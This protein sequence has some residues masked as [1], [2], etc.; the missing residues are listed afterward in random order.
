MSSVNDDHPGRGSL[1]PLSCSRTAAP[2][3]CQDKD[4]EVGSCPNPWKERPYGVESRSYDAYL[5]TGSYAQWPF[6]YLH[7][8]VGFCQLSAL[9]HGCSHL[10][11]QAHPSPCLHLPSATCPSY[12]T[13]N[14]IPPASICQGHQASQSEGHWTDR[15]PFRAKYQWLGWDMRFG[16]MLWLQ[17]SFS[18]P[19]C[20]A[21]PQYLFILFLL[22]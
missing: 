11:L 16:T 19:C 1:S 21:L 17:L 20:A 9:S 6:K 4:E 7:G 18:A 22:Y 15:C 12:G 8:T 13:L 3:L 5:R 10:Q 2:T 14:R